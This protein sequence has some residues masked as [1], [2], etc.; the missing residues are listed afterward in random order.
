MTGSDAIYVATYV[1]VLPPAADPGA[2]LLRAEVEASAN[3]PGVLRF[4]AY[5]RIDRSNQLVV[6]SVW[7]DERALVKH[8]SAR[9]VKQLGEDLGPLLAAPNDSRQHHAL[10][11]G[12]PAT[13]R[14]ASITV[15][16]HVDVV[17]PHKDGGAAA[18]MLLAE[19][20]REHAGNL[21]FEVW[22]QNDRP[23]HFTIVETWTSRRALE[24]HVAAAETLAF[25]RQLATMT[26]AL[27]DERR[28]RRLT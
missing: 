10:T 12:T 1:E 14:R 11:R 8:R 23:N 9:H 19:A 7:R 15:V 13:L 26:G 25:R 24:A 28:Y 2:A 20:S 4:E 21:G 3:D 17:P 18:L 16:T 6:L 5:R 22:R 27:Y